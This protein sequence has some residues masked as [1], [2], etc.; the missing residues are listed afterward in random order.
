[1]NAALDLEKKAVIFHFQNNQLLHLP[2]WRSTVARMFFT[3][4]LCES[5]TKWCNKWYGQKW[6][7]VGVLNKTLL[8]QRKSKNVL[9]QILLKVP[10]THSSPLGDENT[11]WLP[12]RQN[13]K[14]SPNFEKVY[15]PHNTAHSFYFSIYI[16]T[17][18]FFNWYLPYVYILLTREKNVLFVGN[19]DIYFRDFIQ[20]K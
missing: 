17:L 1:M 10:S 13:Q 9:L 14:R 3:R 12:W 20:K 19:Q 6:K 2:N 5:W 7:I 15:C 4:I 8:L 18:Y 16:K 11:R